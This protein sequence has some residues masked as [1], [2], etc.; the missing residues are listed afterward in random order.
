[1]LDIKTIH[2]HEEKL[3]EQ[4][5]TLLSHAKSWE[6]IRERLTKADQITLE[7]KPNTLDTKS[8]VPHRMFWR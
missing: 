7:G 8:L 5:Q 6:P 4:P 1:M 3:M 2:Y